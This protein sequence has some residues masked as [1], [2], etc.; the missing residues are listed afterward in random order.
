M[1]THDRGMGEGRHTTNNICCGSSERVKIASCAA[2]SKDPAHSG[3]LHYWTWTV[4]A[5][6]CFSPLP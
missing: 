3:K 6:S 4:R 2:Q 5:E 1:V